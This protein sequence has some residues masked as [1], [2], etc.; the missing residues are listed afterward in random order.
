[1]AMHQIQLEEDRPCALTYV[2]SMQWQLR[3]SCS[4]FFQVISD[5]DN[6]GLARCR[7][8]T[9]TGS[10]AASWSSSRAHILSAGSMAVLASPLLLLQQAGNAKP[11]RVLGVAI[12]C[13]A[14]CRA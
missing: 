2:N 12:G 13:D 6:G 7:A 8:S 9:R 10:P 14:T 1:M 4:P 11:M 5:S 3:W